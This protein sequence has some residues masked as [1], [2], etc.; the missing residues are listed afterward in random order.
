MASPVLAPLQGMTDLAAPEVFLWQRIE[1]AFREVLARYGFTEIRTPVLERIEVFARAIGAE[2]DVV[3]KEMYAFED[4]GGR[5]VALRP[6]GTAGAIRYAAGAGATEARI[7][8]LGPMFRAERPQAGRRRQFHQLG[9]EALGPPSPAADAECVALQAH[10]LDAIGLDGFTLRVNTRGAAGDAEA[11]AAGLRAALAP[12]ADGLCADCARR[13]D[14]N[15]LRVLDC[16]QPGCRTL[17]QSLPPVTRFMAEPSRAYLAEV[18]RLLRRLEIYAVEDPL[19]VRGLDYYRHTIWEIAHPAL[20]AQDALSGGGRYAIDLAG[21]TVEGVGFAMGLERLVMALQARGVEPA[22]PAADRRIW[23]V[24]AGDAVREDNLVL[25]QALRRR[26]IPCS[27]D[28]AG[29]SLKAQMRA[30][31]R[32]AVRRVVLRG[33]QE[34][35]RGVYRLKDMRDGSE[36]ELDLPALIEALTG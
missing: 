15:V 10:L 11:V 19:L 27:L 18:Q 13:R 31:G 21:R 28:L 17:V 5:R 3:Q 8:Y 20:G 26:G 34:Q 6:E 16:K 29:R 7:F 24:S 12:L 9:I 35:A 1:D 36:R 2:T 32:A 4:R 30:A 22:D 33:E 25:A 14:R 23:I